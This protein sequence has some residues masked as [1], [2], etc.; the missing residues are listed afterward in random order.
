MSGRKS[1]RKIPEKYSIISSADD[2]YSL[3]INRG[4]LLHLTNAVQVAILETII[5]QGFP[6]TG[7][8]KNKIFEPY[9]S[10][11][12]VFLLNTIEELTQMGYIRQFHIYS[13]MGPDYAAFKLAPDF[14]RTLRIVQQNGIYYYPEEFRKNGT[15]QA[16][17][18]SE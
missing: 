2:L 13:K 7:V 15:Y 18:A 14:F 3:L 5:C 8:V 10:L 11:D 16:T 17:I 4:G 6:K 1:A 9:A 12:I